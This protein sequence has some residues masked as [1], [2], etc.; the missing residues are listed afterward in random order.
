M[1]SIRNRPDGTFPLGEALLNLRQD[2]VISLRLAPLAK[3][4]PQVQA[5]R[6]SPYAPVVRRPIQRGAGKNGKDSS[7][8]TRDERKMAQDGLR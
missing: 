4:G 1:T 7:S 5:P 8:A 6:H 2:P 3:L